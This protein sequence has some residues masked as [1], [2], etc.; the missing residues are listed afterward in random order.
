M[1]DSVEPSLQQNAYKVS[2]LLNDCK[3]EL[4][5]LESKCCLPIRSQQMTKIANSLDQ[6]M[7]TK[8]EAMN[9]HTADTDIGFVKECGA[10][11]GEL[12]ATCCA[13]G[14]E[15]HYIA[16][17]RLLGQLHTELWKTKSVDN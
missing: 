10:A 6:F 3:K 17:M 16:V 11:I 2:G 5:I 8:A 15:K 14:R 12:F 1:E 7:F 9:E 13:P 4:A